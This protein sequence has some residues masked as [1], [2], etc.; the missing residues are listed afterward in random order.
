MSEHTEVIE[1]GHWLIDTDVLDS[2]KVAKDGSIDTD[3][4]ALDEGD[5][6]GLR[7]PGVRIDF[8]QSGIEEVEQ[9]QRIVISS[10]I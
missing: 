9:V 10:S 1:G 2:E 8:T 5:N 6:S 7:E 3:G 4:A